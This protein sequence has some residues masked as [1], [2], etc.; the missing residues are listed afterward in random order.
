MGSCDCSVR[1]FA[2]LIF[3]TELKLGVFDLGKILE[4]YR[5]IS[6]NNVMMAIMIAITV[7]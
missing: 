2:C 1:I 3:Y 4:C 7:I 6:A 5:I